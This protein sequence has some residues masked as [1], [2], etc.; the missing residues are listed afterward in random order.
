MGKFV[1]LSGLGMAT[2]GEASVN[3]TVEESSKDATK[4]TNAVAEQQ[5]DDGKEVVTP[6]ATTEAAAGDAKK[7]QD[8]K[9]DPRRSKSATRSPS[10]EPELGKRLHQRFHVLV[11]YQCSRKQL[12]AKAH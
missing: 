2:S 11:S 7:K 8:D 10:P 12:M 9:R 5:K 3:H 6:K 4:P 1:D